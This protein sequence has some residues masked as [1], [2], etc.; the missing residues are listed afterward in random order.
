MSGGQLD[1]GVGDRRSAAA[2]DGARQ[3]VHTREV[4]CRSYLRTDGLWDIEGRLTDIRTDD[5]RTPVLEVSAGDPV[6]DMVICMTIDHE[7]VIQSVSARVLSGATP[8]CDR[9]EGNYDRLCGVKIGVGFR[10]AVKAAVGG[11]AG[12]THLTTLLQAMATAA[13]QAMWH[14]DPGNDRSGYDWVV[15]SCQGYR[16]DGEPVRL[17]FP[18]AFDGDAAGRK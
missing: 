6:H 17:L 18:Q 1:R 13:V 10:S 7:M 2:A 12:C 3:L 14:K 11:T 5:I 4:S 15:N 8:I 9:I 16:S